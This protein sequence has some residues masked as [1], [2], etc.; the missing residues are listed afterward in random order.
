MIRRHEIR[1]QINRFANTKKKKTSI[2]T[3]IHRRKFEHKFVR[4]KK[5]DCKKKFKNLKISKTKKKIMIRQK[6]HKSNLRKKI[7]SI[8]NILN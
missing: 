8:L 2:F 6:K 1:I 7:Y 3:Y 4:N 5:F